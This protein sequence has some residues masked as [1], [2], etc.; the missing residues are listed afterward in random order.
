MEQKLELIL[1]G[2]KFMSLIN[3]QFSGIRE[4]YSLKEAEIQ[5]LF[6]LSNNQEFN[7]ARDINGFLLLNKGY[8]SQTVDS[9]INKKLITSLMDNNDRRYIHYSLTDGAKQII[10]DID[11]VKAEVECGI[12][13]GIS[14]D[15]IALLKS[16][17]TQ[18]NSN[19]D[20]ML[21]NR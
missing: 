4:K 9:L 6:Y 1:R 8:I 15:E 20:N 18:I 7:T 11:K 2:R 19:I 3:S 5:V 14:S 12:F 13:N 21:A 17:A 10:D 16:I